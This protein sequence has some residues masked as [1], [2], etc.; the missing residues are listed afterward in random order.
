MRFNKVILITGL[1]FVMLSLGIN[2]YAC[3]SVV[4]GKG[5][6][7]DGSVM[8]THTCDGWYD[9]RLVVVPG[10]TF[11]P[12]AVTPIYHNICI[13]TRPDKELIKVGEIPQVEKTYTY[14]KV[15]GTARTSDRLQSD[16]VYGYQWDANGNLTAK[17]TSYIY[18]R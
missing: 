8:T 18:R 15:P 11:E 6:S 10:Q 3:T 2:A 12:G 5:A 4:V 16:S 1:I 9:A 17:G 14:Y 13:F 7:V